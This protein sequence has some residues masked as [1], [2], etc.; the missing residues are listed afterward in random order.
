MGDQPMIWKFSDGTTVELGGKVEG[1]SVL[2]QELR[3]EIASGRESV[4]IWPPPGGDV[5]LD[6]SDPAILEA[7]LRYKLDIWR[8]LDRL[9]IRL[10]SPE[11]IPPLPPCPYHATADLG[12]TGVY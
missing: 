12:D 2:A 6:V 9:G 11:G 5:P 1:P 7:W 10:Q 8:R 3:D 4:T